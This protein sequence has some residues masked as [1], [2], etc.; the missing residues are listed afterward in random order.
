[1]LR[2]LCH[3][4]GRISISTHSSVG[5]RG[6]S[7]KFGRWRSQEHGVVQRESGIIALCH[8][9]D[10][11]TKLQRL[12]AYFNSSQ[13][14]AIGFLC[15]TMLLLLPSVKDEDQACNEALVSVAVPKSAGELES[16]APLLTLQSNI[17]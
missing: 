3:E 11:S 1:M 13:L 16:L 6:V 2:M 4:V 8:S 14:V 17:F 9:I 10:G 12:K 5:W 7:V 15:K